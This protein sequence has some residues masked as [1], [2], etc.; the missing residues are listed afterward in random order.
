MGSF[1]SLCR[2]PSIDDDRE[3]LLSRQPQT[4]AVSEDIPPPR[5]HIDKAAD[6]FAAF[7]VGKLPSQEQINAAL[8][9]ALRSQVLTVDADKS[10][11]VLGLKQQYGPLSERG[12]LLLKDVRELVEAIIQFGMEKNGPSFSRLDSAASHRDVLGKTMIV[13]R[14]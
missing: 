7:H 4:G 2:R 12:K 8:Q 3:P 13:Y 14:T 10:A 5:S 9:K 11:R 1:L 6:V